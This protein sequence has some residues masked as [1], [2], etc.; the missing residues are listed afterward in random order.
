M[1]TNYCKEL[2]DVLASLGFDSVD[3]FKSYMLGKAKLNEYGSVCHFEQRDGLELS[4]S[5]NCKKKF[6]IGGNLRGIFTDNRFN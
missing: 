2:L 3:S 1:K 6:G 4:Y 5:D